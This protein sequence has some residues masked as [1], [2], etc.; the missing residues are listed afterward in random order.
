[1]WP[2]DQT[3]W[4]L[5]VG[6]L[7]MLY[8]SILV[9][10]YGVSEAT[11]L[12]FIIIL[13]LWIGYQLSPLLAY[14]QDEPWQNFLL[15]PAYLD[16]T[17]EYSMLAMVALLIG[18]NSI[19]RRKDIRLR[20]S[21]SN[22]WL[23][24]RIKWSWI[25]GLAI[26]VFSLTVYTTGGLSA[27][28]DAPYSRGELQWAART[29]ETRIDQTLNV[30]L[31]PVAVVL[32]IVSSLYILRNPRSLFHLMVGGFGLLIGMLPSMHGFSR[33]TGFGFF[34][35]AFL[36]IKTTPLNFK[37]GAIFLILMLLGYYLGSVGIE[38]RGQY[39]PGIYNY[40]HAIFFGDRIDTNQISVPYI[41]P[42]KNSLDA[43]SAFT[44]KLYQRYM[45]SDFSIIKNI[46]I[47]L[48]NIN[49]FPSQL[50]DPGNI[51]E[52]LS[53]FMSTTGSTGLTT[54]MLAEINYAFTYY[55]L[56]IIII[57]G[58]LY[59]HIDR[60]AIRH[61]GAFAQILV[62][63]GII[64]AAIGLHS[65]I[66]AQTRPLLYAFFLIAAFNYIK[67]KKIWSRSFLLFSIKNRHTTQ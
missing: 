23:V 67:G 14:F 29:V 33:G 17:L 25:L 1:M 49:P 3:L 48:I 10:K 27:F 57:L 63:L 61:P 31:T 7:P 37:T 9:F 26:I 40:S 15:M 58:M 8:V 64:S 46:S 21:Q 60:Y 45:T 53:E 54:P 56:F 19:V 55:G 16:D 44:R 66:R 38:Q 22:R 35:L 52:P 20:S 50:V 30:I 11:S 65:G 18:Y 34:I 51:G 4:W 24:P 2:S 42:S 62:F 6:G 36:M 5:I 59:G 39:K 43:S 28:W 12:R 41:D 47:F 13:L 32:V